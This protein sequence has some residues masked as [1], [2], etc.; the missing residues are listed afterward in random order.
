MS[1]DSL[2]SKPS[3]FYVL[4]PASCHPWAQKFC[5][6]IGAKM[7]VIKDAEALQKIYQDTGMDVNGNELLIWNGYNDIEKVC[8]VG[9]YHFRSIVH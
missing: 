2:C 6:D 9:E 1:K 5:K 8:Y 3:P 4:G 7:A